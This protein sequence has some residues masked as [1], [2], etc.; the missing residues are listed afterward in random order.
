[1]YDTCLSSRS[2]QKHPFHFIRVRLSAL[3]F[4]EGVGAGFGVGFD[5]GSGVGFV[6]GLGVGFS[7]GFGV[8]TGVG[9]RARFDVGAGVPGIELR[10]LGFLDSRKLAT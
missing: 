4:V 10:A 7:V 2:S 5:V 3:S 6:L 9:T 8:G 1:M